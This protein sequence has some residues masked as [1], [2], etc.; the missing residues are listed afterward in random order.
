MTDKKLREICDTFNKAIWSGDGLE[1]A[2]AGD[3]FASAFGVDTAIRLL[4]RIENL[5]AALRHFDEE[6]ARRALKRDDED[7]R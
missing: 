4:D 7:S 5:R 2:T 6:I 3:E 1:E